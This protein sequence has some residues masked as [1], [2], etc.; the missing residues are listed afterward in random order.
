VWNDIYSTQVAFCSALQATA[1]HLILTTI[2]FRVSNLYLPPNE[3]LDNTALS[4]LLTLLQIPLLLVG[5]FNVCHFLWGSHYDR[6]S[7]IERVTSQFT[8]ALLNDFSVPT[9]V[10]CIIHTHTNWLA[11]CSPE[12][13]TVFLACGWWCPK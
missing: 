3:P 2:T 11:F 7:L 5:R 4:N 10:T 13:S 6:G 8:P 1:V 12:L 9:F